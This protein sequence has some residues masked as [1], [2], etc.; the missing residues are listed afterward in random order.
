MNHTDAYPRKEQVIADLKALNDTAVNIVLEQYQ[1]YVDEITKGIS[2]AGQEND[3]L[4]R[5]IN[6]KDIIGFVL[7]NLWRE[8]VQ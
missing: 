3:Q 6:H 4:R 2:R 7:L 1:F 5:L 8:M